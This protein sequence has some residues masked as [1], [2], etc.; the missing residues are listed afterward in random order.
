MMYPYIKVNQK[1]YKYLRERGLSPRYENEDGS[2]YLWKHDLATLGGNNDETIRMIGGVGMSKDE[3][4]DEQRGKTKI[5]LPLAE[6]DRFAVPVPVED[7]DKESENSITTLPLQEDVAV[8]AENGQDESSNDD[9]AT[10]PSDGGVRVFP[11]K[12]KG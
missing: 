3:V 6:D 7:A 2:V 8:G 12:K 1:V 5:V 4:A 9:I 11:T 10:I